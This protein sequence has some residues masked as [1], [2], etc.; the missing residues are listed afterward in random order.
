M[1]LQTRGSAEIDKAQR[2]LAGLKS[3]DP[4]LDLGYGLT[5]G[6]YTQLIDTIQGEIA[7]H[8]QRVAEIDASR[9]TLNEY[10]RTLAELSGR[11]LSAVK[12]KYGGNSKEYSQAGGSIRKKSTTS[13]PSSESSDSTISAAIATDVAQNGNGRAKKSTVAS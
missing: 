8:N 7:R 10:D 3:I 9:K 5:I 4:N 12:I 11:I 6:A 1:G 13:N 2:R